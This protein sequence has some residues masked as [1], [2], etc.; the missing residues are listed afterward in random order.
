[1]IAVLKDLSDKR[2]IDHLVDLAKQV[3]DWD[4]AVI[5]ITAVERLLR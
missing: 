3:V 1:M 5:E 4:D 2:K